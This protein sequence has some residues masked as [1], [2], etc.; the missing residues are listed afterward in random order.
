MWRNAPFPEGL[1]CTI[2]Q[3]KMPKLRGNN[4]LEI[5]VLSR[6]AFADEGQAVSNEC[7]AS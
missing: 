1:C 7:M 6:D 3:V 4:R 5:C 2:T